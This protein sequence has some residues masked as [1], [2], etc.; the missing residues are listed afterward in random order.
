MSLYS[1]KAT[2]K[3]GTIQKGALEASSALE[4]KVSLRQLEL[5]LITYSVKTPFLF[6][7]KV[8]PRLL[9]D[10][11]LHLEQFENAGIPLR[12]NLE[13]L[14]HLQTI[15][16]LKAI[17]GE[18][19]KDVEGGSLF[20]KALEK[21][22]SVFDPVF[23]GLITAGEKTGRFSF[24]LRQLFQHL[25]WMDEL[26]A[27]I[28]KALRYPLIMAV[29]LLSVIM[30]LMTTVVPELVKFIETFAGNIPLSTLFLISISKFLSQNLFLFLLS[31]AI[32]PLGF[33]SFFRLHA[34]G[35]Y[36]KDR[37][38]DLFPFLGPLRRKLALARFCHVFAVMFESGIDIIQA[39][40]TA[41]K[42]L[43]YGRMY[44]AL[45]DAERFIKEG[46]SLSNAFQKVD[47]FPPIVIQMVKI[48]EKTSSLQK[49][50]FHVKEYFDTTLKRQVDHTVGLLEP[51]M[52]LCL[53]CLMACII[54]SVF[55]PLYNTLSLLDY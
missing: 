41:R 44:H 28:F 43:K 20:S 30:I 5:S 3:R 54:Y 25:K 53:G 40:Q 8:K 1:Y 33:V 55:L 17:L 2:D 16:R 45:E 22:P 49:T 15:P 34:K 7:R 21:H 39:L 42:H 14:Y 4:L 24:A 29:V 19:L 9:M 18:V 6:S 27:Q 26:Q 13:D 52:I 10:L 50:L 12:E 46:Q 35:P 51:I 36:W 37:L 47:F 11:C 38:L 31:V 48:G 23:I 32:L